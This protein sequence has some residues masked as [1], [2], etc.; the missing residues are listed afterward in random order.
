MWSLSFSIGPPCFVLS[1]SLSLFSVCV[2]STH[3]FGGLCLASSSITLHLE[4]SHRPPN[5]PILRGLGSRLQGS[6]SLCLPSSR[7]QE[8]TTSPSFFL[9]CWRPKLGSSDHLVIS[10]TPQHPCFEQPERTSFILPSPS[11]L[12]AKKGWRGPQLQS[13]FSSS[14]SQP[15]LCFGFSAR[16]LRFFCSQFFSL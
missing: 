8:H 12:L 13:V 10:P 4:L 5:S 15:F 11:C 7:T 9:R 1:L 3:A 14:C 6:S 16:G 2:V